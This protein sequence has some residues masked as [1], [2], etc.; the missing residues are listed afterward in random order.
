MQAHILIL[1]HTHLYTH[2]HTHSENSLLHLNFCL[3]TSPAPHPCFEILTVV[4]EQMEIHGGAKTQW[5]IWL[6][7]LFAT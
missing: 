1:T 3:F 4:P 5:K 7:A 6:P 2:S